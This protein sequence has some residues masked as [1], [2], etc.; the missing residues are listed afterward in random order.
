M[1]NSARVDR[2]GRKELGRFLIDNKHMSPDWAPT[3]EAVDRAAFLPPVIWPWTMETRESHA[4]DQAADPDAWY[5][6]VD[7]D[8]PIVTQWDDGEHI[9]TRPGRTPTSSSSGPSVN[10][11]LFQDLAVE[12]GMEV[13]DVGTGTGETAGALYHRCARN[14]G[15]GAWRGRGRVTTIDV[16]GTISRQARERLCAAGLYPDVYVGDGAQGYPPNAPYDRIL[17]TAGLR[18]SPGALV[19][20][21]RPGGIIVAP[22]GTPFSNADAV[23]RL[24]AKN[25]RASGHFTRPVEFMKLRAQRSPVRHDDYVPKDAMESAQVSTTDVPESEFITGRY[26]ALNFALGLRVRNC[27]QAVADK[28]DGQRPVWFYG[29]GEPTSSWACVMFRDGAPA[30]VWQGGP[31]RLWEEVESAYGWWVRQGKPQQHRFGLTVGP[32]GQAAWLDDPANAWT[33]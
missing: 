7:R 5:A 21:T 11:R 18:Q 17:V 33:V 26:T 31:R 28:R 6:A 2:P 20:Q 12:E 9:G 32:E 3:F 4:V 24:V 27:V 25:G 29:S 8:E 13:L 23:V 19:R 16:D 14:R 10:Y 30:K 1:L 22:W 15:H